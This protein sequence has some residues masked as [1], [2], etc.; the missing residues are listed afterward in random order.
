MGRN[1]DAFKPEKYVRW[2]VEKGL[3]VLLA[4][5]CGKLVRKSLLNRDELSSDSAKVKV[6]FNFTL[7]GG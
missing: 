5:K 4:S 7:S 6:V 3:V 1:S 2:I